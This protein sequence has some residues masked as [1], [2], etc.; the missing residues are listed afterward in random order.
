MSIGVNLKVRVLMCTEKV[1]LTEGRVAIRE[2]A[3]GRWDILGEDGALM[4][5]L[6]SDY[7][8]RDVTV[9]YYGYDAGHAEGMPAG[10]KAGYDMGRRIM[11][12]DVIEALGVFDVS[13]EL[14]ALERILADVKAMEDV[15]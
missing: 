9:F 7:T 2:K 4:R 3:Q 5:T 8:A 1:Q 12:S 10:Y 11:R 6:P 15:K 13:K 14:K